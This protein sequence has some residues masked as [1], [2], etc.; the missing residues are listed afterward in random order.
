[1]RR[2]SCWPPLQPRAAA[3]RCSWQPPKYILGKLYDLLHDGQNG[4]GGCH[5]GVDNGASAAE[6]PGNGRRAGESEAAGGSGGKAARGRRPAGAADPCV[7]F[8]QAT[9]IPVTGLGQFC[10]LLAAVVGRRRTTRTRLNHACSRSHAVI[11]LGIVGPP[12]TDGA[13]L[14]PPTRLQL[15][16]LVGSECTELSGAVGQQLCEAKQNNQDVLAVTRV[17]AAL[18]DDRH[19]PVRSSRLTFLLAPALGGTGLSV[20]LVCVAPTPTRTT[21]ASL[22]LGVDAR[23]ARARRLSPA[24]AALGLPRRPVAAGGAA[25]EKRPPPPLLSAAL[26]RGEAA[27]SIPAL[28]ERFDHCN[29]VAYFRLTTGK[30]MILKRHVDTC[31]NSYLNADLSFAK[32]PESGMTR[33]VGHLEGIF[34]VFS[35]FTDS[36]AARAALARRLKYLRSCP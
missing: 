1:M 13:M 11:T 6:G 21:V 18:R 2:R 30:G 10:A 22:N 34:S 12:A 20:L 33:A 19:V 14:P 16:D 36:W 17:L 23:G 3:A 31:I 8:D 4:G 5:G 29:P 35:Y 24:A 28:H 26:A 15:V 25:T 7:S 32:Q 9:A 27:R